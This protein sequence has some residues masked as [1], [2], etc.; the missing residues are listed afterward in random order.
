MS[1]GATAQLA[2]VAADIATRSLSV[3]DARRL[4]LL[5]LDHI[6]VA[7]A[8]SN[9]LN[10][11]Q[12]RSA[13]VP[14]AR[15]GPAQVLGNR[16]KLEPATAAYLNAVASHAEELDDTHDASLTHPGAVTFSTC[17]ALAATNPVSG[18]TLLAAAA[19]G[20]LAICSIGKGVGA[21]AVAE[22]GFHPTAVFGGFGSAASAALLLGLTRDQLIGSWGLVLSSAG[23]SMQFSQESD[24]AAI[25]LIH[26]G[27]AARDGIMA[28]LLSRC[29]V[30]G[31]SAVLEGRY[32][33]FQLFSKSRARDGFN[34]F[35]PYIHQIT[36][37][38][39]PSCRPC[40][41]ALEAALE[42]LSTGANADHIRRIVVIGPSKLRQHLERRPLSSQ[43]AQY[44]LPYV[45]AAA[46]L[47][48]PQSLLPFEPE[49]L[50]DPR[51]LALADRVEIVADEG[52]NRQFPDRIGSR[53]IL[54]LTN[55]TILEASR[56][57]SLGTPAR[58]L[59]E[60]QVI[61]KARRLMRRAGANAG[62]IETLVDTVLNIASSRSVGPLL[63]AIATV[64]GCSVRSR[65]PGFNS[66]G[67]GIRHSRTG[68][69]STRSVALRRRPPTANVSSAMAD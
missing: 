17:M 39:Y 42:C 45:I 27:A 37:K 9:N 67:P 1:V 28:A 4:S 55:G 26:A 61:E 63:E 32:G 10:A 51:R 50:T 3:T 66:D 11:V 56:A 13:I 54:H 25:K 53:V 34:P 6:A 8:G 15:A 14:T 58:P 46:I 21:A 57:D 23:G 62:A 22:A 65:R 24:G 60:E 35:E 16:R 29:G 31:P 12:I 7:L 48:G 44:S 30:R 64:N 43:A 38:N 2:T 59:P 5:L 49:H 40:H 41:A 18:I 52:Y 69:A 47:D 33:V 19:A 20:Y 36:V 68:S